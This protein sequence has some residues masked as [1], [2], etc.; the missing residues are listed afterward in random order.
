MRIRNLFV[1]VFIIYFTT[2][3]SQVSK[4]SKV[5]AEMQQYFINYSKFNLDSL[6]Q[7][8]FRIIRKINQRQ[9][10]KVVERKRDFNVRESIFEIEVEYVN[11]KITLHKEYRVHVF[12][13][14]G[15]IFGLINYDVYQDKVKEY[16]DFTEFSNYLDS[17]NNFYQSKVTAKGFVDQVL[18]EHVYG[19]IC[20]FAP[21]IY[22]VP[23]YN[24]VL[25]DKKRNINKFRNW[26]KSFN[27]ELQTYGVMALEY[28]EKNKGITLT[29]LDKKIISNIKKRNSILNTCSGCTFGI[30]EKVFK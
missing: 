14:S 28:L 16:F 23:R 12:S 20:G 4:S 25:F 15:V 29:E 19:F 22:E 9:T 13:K 11:N 8:E 18:A 27:P 17:H 30:Y 2:S 7:T 6:K 24:N 5:D 21:A 10:Y 3:F 1:I 26:V